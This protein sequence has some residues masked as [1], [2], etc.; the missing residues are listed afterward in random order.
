MRITQG[1]TR[2]GEI[3]TAIQ[4]DCCH[5][6]FTPKDTLEWQELTCISYTGGYGSIF[7]DG[8]D[9]ECDLCQHCLKKLLGPYL[10]VGGDWLEKELS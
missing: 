4:C 7:G 9:I 3:L 1:V 5:K 2:I 10:R 6:Q 8:A